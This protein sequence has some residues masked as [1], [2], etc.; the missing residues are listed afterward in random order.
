MFS[1]PESSPPRVRWRCPVCQT[2]ITVVG[3]DK[4]PN[5]CGSPMT[6][7][8]I[9]VGKYDDKEKSEVEGEFRYETIQNTGIGLV[10]AV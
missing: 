2:T 1:M 6:A 5:H 8:G 10:I 3:N 7:I 9:T 4:K